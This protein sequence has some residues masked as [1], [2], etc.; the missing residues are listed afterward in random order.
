L[1]VVRRDRYDDV[2][3]AVA[4]PEGPD[5]ELAGVTF[6]RGQGCAECNNT[7]YRG[8]IGIYELMEVDGPVREA[9]ANQDRAGL[10]QALQAQPSHRT[11]RES[12]LEKA[13]AGI[14]SLEEVLRV[15]AEDL[16]YAEFDPDAIRAPAP[17]ASLALEP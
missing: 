14:T 3:D 11:L 7:G 16:E 5:E 13:K 12:G 6:Y 1:P 8:R 9:I 15:T 10:E 17:A 4:R 2:A